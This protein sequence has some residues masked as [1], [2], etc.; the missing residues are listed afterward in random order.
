MIGQILFIC[1]TAQKVFFFWHFHET[2]FSSNHYISYTKQKYALSAYFF[3]QAA[4]CEF[5]DL[6][7]CRCFHFGRLIVFEIYHTLKK[8]AMLFS[9]ET[10]GF[11]SIQV[12]DSM[13]N[14]KQT[15]PH[16]EASTVAADWFVS[17]AFFLCTFWSTLS[18]PS[19]SNINAAIFSLLTLCRIYFSI[20]PDLPKFAT[21]GQY[22]EF[23]RVANGLDDYFEV[24]SDIED[25]D[26]GENEVNTEKVFSNR[27]FLILKDKAKHSKEFFFFQS[28]CCTLSKKTLSRTIHSAL[29]CVGFES[30]IKL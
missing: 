2:S 22:Y 4:R 29:V 3:V 20:L 24:G 27:I 30:H 19:F 6:S 15:S 13:E 9:E 21:T 11:T 16:S 1:L 14:L 8:L 18:G 17:F 25:D 28:T 23:E 7:S 26:F 12:V 10:L 5:P